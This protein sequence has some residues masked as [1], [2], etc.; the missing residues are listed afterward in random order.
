MA[1]VTHVL[2]GAG[3]PLDPPP[4]IGAHYVNTNN[5]ALGHLEAVGGSGVVWIRDQCK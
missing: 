3:E 4:S 1:T 2:S 5:G